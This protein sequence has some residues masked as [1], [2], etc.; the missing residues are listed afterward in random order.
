MSGKAT[1][2]MAKP[3]VRVNDEARPWSNRAATARKTKAKRLRTYLREPRIIEAAIRERTERRSALGRPMRGMRKVDW[4]REQRTY[5]KAKTAKT[6]E[7]KKGESSLWER[8]EG[9]KGARQP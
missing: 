4:K 6:R 8:R 2:R 5:E 1:E 3:R 7:L 9:K